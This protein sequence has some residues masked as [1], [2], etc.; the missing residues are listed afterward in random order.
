MPLAALSV[1][2]EAVAKPS[3]PVEVTLVKAPYVAN[4]LVAVALVMVVPSRLLRPVTA[5][6]VVVTLLPVALPK[7]KPS[8][9]E[10]APVTANV[11]VT[12]K[13]LLMVKAP[14][15]VPPANWIVLVV[16]LP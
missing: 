8:P 10:T 9:N 5:K 1:V 4:K 7:V 15:E 14:V 13:L 12:V 11:P 6:L 2:P 3:Q 16:T